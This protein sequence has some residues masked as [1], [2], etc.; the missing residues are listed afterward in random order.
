[1]SAIATTP[2]RCLDGIDTEDAVV[3]VVIPGSDPE[4]S[5]CGLFLARDAYV[6]PQ[7][8]TEPAW[9]PTCVLIQDSGL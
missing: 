5:F 7:E 2:E 4:A 1:M 8:V 6:P 9:C 3:H